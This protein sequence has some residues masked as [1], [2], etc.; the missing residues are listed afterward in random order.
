VRA[1]AIVTLL[2]GCVSQSPSTPP[3]ADSH[4]ETLMFPGIKPP[5]LDLLIV[6]DDTAAMAPYVERTQAMLRDVASLW[7]AMAYEMP[8][9]HIAVATETGELSATDRVHGPFID[10]EHIPDLSL[11]RMTNFDGDFG[12]AIAALGAVG[13]T[14]TIHRPLEA[15]RAALESLPD[16]V[17]D[18][19][20]LVILLVSA[21]DDASTVTPAD[22]AAWAK[23]L[24]SDPNMVAVSGVFPASATR[25]ADFV[26]QFPN[27][28]WTTSIDA[29]DYAMAVDLLRQLQ[30]STLI[31]PC[32]DAPMDVDPAT[33]GPQY[34]CTVE[35]VSETGVTEV[36]PACPAARCWT[37]HPDVGCT[38]GGTI[39]VAPFKAP[40]MPS[41]NVQCVVAN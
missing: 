36:E 6:V 21:N 1:L 11:R 32:L 17:R 2:A 24:K 29:S 31:E 12:D 26:A 33:P 28:G 39:E 23:G 16:F 14:G 30:T 40:L 41:M 38:V 9:F 35:L 10:D 25:L 4:V 13:T 18:D 37:F 7:P 8:D 19:S 3:P 5:T 22:A 15:M 34:D 27:R 20:L